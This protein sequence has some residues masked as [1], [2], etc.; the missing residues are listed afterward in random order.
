MQ[1]FPLPSEFSFSAFLSAGWRLLQQRFGSFV[2]IIGFAVLLIVIPQILVGMLTGSSEDLGGL[3][4]FLLSFWNLF[5]NMGLIKMTID[6]IKGE[7]P[8][9]DKLWAMKEQYWTYLGGTILL[10]LRIMLGY[11]LLIIPGIIWQI[12]FQFVPLL[13]IDKKMSISEAFETSSTMT[14]GHK[15]QLF[16]FSILFTLFTMAG[17]L[18]FFFGVF[19]TGAIASLAYLL[20][21]KYLVKKLD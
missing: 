10:A 4:S 21:Y 13:I 11:I 20:M 17:I 9:L 14:N 19:V 3:I 12:Q 1:A 7:E 8:T 2:K 18:L 5:V 6:V 15:L 16:F